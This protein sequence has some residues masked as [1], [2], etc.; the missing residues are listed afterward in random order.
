VELDRVQQQRQEPPDRAVA[1]EHLLP[2]PFLCRARELAD[3][4]NRVGERI[5]PDT[6]ED[7]AA[8]LAVSDRLIE[9]QRARVRQP[10]PRGVDHRSAA[11]PLGSVPGLRPV[12]NVIEHRVNVIEHLVLRRLL[13]DRGER[14]QRRQPPQLAQILDV[15]GS[16]GASVEH[17]CPQARERKLRDARQR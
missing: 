16:A 4:P 9:D 14:R 1:G 13:R 10:Q 3:L 8:Q 15:A 12:L 6:G 11:E 7:L 5:P 2:V 17:Q